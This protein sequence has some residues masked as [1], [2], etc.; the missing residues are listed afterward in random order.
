MGYS[1]DISALL[2]VVYFAGAG[3]VPKVNLRQRKSILSTIEIQV[4]LVLYFTYIRR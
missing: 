2:I 3:V 1:P 4:E